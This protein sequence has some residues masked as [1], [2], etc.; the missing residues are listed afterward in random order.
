MKLLYTL[1]AYP[2]YLGGAQLHQHLLAQHLLDKHSIQVLCHWNRNRTDWLLG[3]TLNAPSTGDN[4]SVDNIS[5]HRMGLS[6][7]D[8]LQLMPLLPFYYPLMGKVLPSITRILE[9]KIDRYAQS[10]DLVHNVRIGREGLSFASLQIARRYEIPF[11]FTPV[12][13]P[14]WVG[15]RYKE[16]LKLYS[17][18]DR[19]IALTQA[20][21]RI[22][23]ELGVNED[24]IV[25]TGHGPIISS[26]ADPNKFLSTYPNIKVPFVLFLGQHYLY[27]GYQQLLQAAPLVWKKYPEVNFVFIGPSVKQ[28]DQAFEN[29]DKRIHRLGSV[30][31]QTKTNAI[32]AC[33]ML[34]VP[35]TQE[36]FGGVYTE[37]W[38]FYK[39]VIGCPIPAV[40]E[41]VTDGIDGYLVEQKSTCI[42]ERICHLLSHPSIRQAMG[43]AG[44]QKVKQHYTWEK[45]AQKTEQV[46]EMTLSGKSM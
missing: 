12:H 6:I 36:S 17:L 25:V 44:Y 34:C 27:K 45:L 22:L 2:P 29:C 13:H 23:V 39:P 24:R 33:T 16:F 30:D 20:E 11:V 14:R 9:K 40:A 7:I 35:S 28:S 43:K 26:E 10:V 38:S 42:A 5:V 32:A 46:Y 1:T 31:L 3:T 37:A 8:K 19:V 41:V 4:Y 18:A 15:W 21:K